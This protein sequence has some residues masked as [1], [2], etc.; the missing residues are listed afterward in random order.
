LERELGLMFS[1]DHILPTI[2]PSVAFETPLPANPLGGYMTSLRKVRALPD[3]RVLPAHGSTTTRT[4]A[5]ADEL[6]MHHHLRLT[7]CEAL[8][9]DGKNSSFAVADALSWTKRNRT[10]RELDPFNAGLAVLETEVHLELLATQ[11]K[12]VRGGDASVVTYSPRSLGS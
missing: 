5:R 9:N 11:G 3:M 6:L 10:L 1:G 4:H 8:V 7:A 12:I 2:T